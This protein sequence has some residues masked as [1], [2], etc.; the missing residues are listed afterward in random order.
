MTI[1]VHWYSNCSWPVRGAEINRSVVLLHGGILKR[2]CAATSIFQQ[3]WARSWHPI[4]NICAL[5]S[6][7]LPRAHASSSEHLS[8]A[9][10]AMIEIVGIYTN[11][12]SAEL[13]SNGGVMIF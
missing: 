4:L 13:N 9:E 12:H 11:V 2:Q 6:P 5:Y 3:G 7:R 8:V 10:P 1:T